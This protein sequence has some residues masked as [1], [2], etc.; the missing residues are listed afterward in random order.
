MTD[1]Y[2]TKREAIKQYQEESDK[3]RKIRK[4]IKQDAKRYRTLEETTKNE[5]YKL[6]YS[7]VADYLEEIS[8]E[9]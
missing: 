6:A 9:K 4:Q 1:F 5:D 8:K 3:Y 2:S 7:I